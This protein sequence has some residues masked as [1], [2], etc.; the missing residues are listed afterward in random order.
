[1]KK[2]IIIAAIVV[3]VVTFG[4]QTSAQVCGGGVRTYKI[5]VR[6]DRQAVNLRYEL[7]AVVPKN[8]G[9][10][11]EST[12]RYLY[13][14]FFP[15]KE[16]FLS[17]FWINK[18][19]EVKN[20]VA[21]RFLK[22]YKTETFRENPSS[23]DLRPSKHSDVIK[24]GEIDFYTSE[25]FDRPYLLKIYADNYKPQYY[26]SDHLGGCYHKADILLNNFIRLKR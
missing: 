11:Y 2:S 12:A 21:E 15:E 20:S 25:L 3:T 5:F 10:D 17:R 26:I 4:L 18:P 8:V 19:Y 22:N 13:K 1:M 24:D 23:E 16:P 7:I 14:T 6:N 9:E